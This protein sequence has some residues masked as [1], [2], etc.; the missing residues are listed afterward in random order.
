MQATQQD[1]DALYEVQKIDLDIKKFTKQLDELPQKNIILNAR[2]QREAV[3]GKLS[4]IEALEKDAKKRL[5][6]INDEDSSLQKK[7]NG[8]QAA[9]EAAGNDFRNAEARTKE[10]NGIFKRRQELA[11][12][13]AEVDGELA[14]IKQLEDQAATA[15]AEIDETETSATQT[16]KSKGAELMQTI[17]EASA[18]RDHLMENISPAVGD[19]YLKTAKHFDT[20]CIGTLQGSSCSVCRAKIESGRLIEIMNQAPLSTCPACKRILIVE[21]E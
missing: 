6:A 14:Q 20:V 2:K 7:E 12:K 16:F 17:A 19:L 9:I 3:Q 13:R 10:L 8:V 4:K 11:S 15:L 5:L 21:N 1:I 18:A